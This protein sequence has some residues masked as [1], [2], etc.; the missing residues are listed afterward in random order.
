[1]NAGLRAAGKAF[2]IYRYDAHHAFMNSERK[3]VYSA[4]AAK[5]AWEHSLSF[6]KQRLA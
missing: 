5:L 1:M 6:L 2:E 3:E 4:E